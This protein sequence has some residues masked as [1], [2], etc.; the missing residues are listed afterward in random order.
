MGV[1]PYTVASLFYQKLPAAFFFLAHFLVW[2]FGVSFLGALFALSLSIRDTRILR[3]YSNE[4]FHEMPF[5]C[6]DTHVGCSVSTSLK[7]HISNITSK[8]ALG[9]N[10]FWALASSVNPRPCPDMARET[11]GT[12]FE[13]FGGLDPDIARID[14]RELTLTI[15]AAS[16][17]I[18]PGWTSGVRFEHLA[19][20]VYLCGRP[21][22]YP[23]T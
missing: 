22:M 23:K 8:N 11:S 12:L 7:I 3:L 21:R 4:W 16:A 14:L 10:L 18:W 20:C 2:S 13:H 17:Q 5:R 19:V 9:H 1:K 15:L 6:R